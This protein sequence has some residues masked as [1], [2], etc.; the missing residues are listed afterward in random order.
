MRK[1]KTLA[2]FLAIA[3]VFCYMPGMAFADEA[4]ND[5]TFADMPNDW[6]TEALTNAVANGLISGYDEADGAKL[7]K[8]SGDL[9]RAEMA[10]IVNR[11]FG[12]A[13]KAALTGVSD[14][15][16]DAW[17]A[18]EIQKAIK[19]GTF[20]SDNKMRPNDSITR[21]E[22]FT[23][24][25]RAFKVSDSDSNALDSFADKGNVA[26]WAADG[27]SGLVKDGYVAG[28]GGKLNP[29]AS[30]TRAEFAKI[31]DNMVKVY[32]TTAGTVKEVANGNVMINVPG[33][34]LDGVTINGNLIIGDGVGDGDVT[35]NNVKVTGETIVR[36]AG[37]NSFI[38]KG[39][40]DLGNIIVAKV[41]GN[42]RIFVEGGAEVEV[43]YI[44]D[45][46]D[47]VV[48]EG[49]VGSIEVAAAAVP[50]V[51][52]NAT[53]GQINV[54]AE[55]AD[56]TLGNGAT[57]TNVNIGASATGATV[58]AQKGATITNVETNAES[59]TVKGDGTVK[60]VDVKAN[61]T[62]VNTKGTTVKVDK[63]V[64][65]TTAGGKDVSGGT[66]ATLPGGSAAGGGGGGS[67]KEAVSAI[68]VTPTEMELTVGATGT[69]TA[70]VEPDD[71]TNRDVTW[72]S[73]KP[74]VATVD[75]NGLV[76]AIAV[77]E[78]TITATANA[79]TKKT[80]TV[81]VTVKEEVEARTVT[82]VADLDDINVEFGGDYTLPTEVEI[83]LS[84][85]EKVTVPVTWEDTVDVNVA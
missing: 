1:R 54:T 25:A 67:S 70:T 49:K 7:I 41:D 63:G 83:T 62:N 65:G 81:T 30:I 57:V 12:A 31:M 10:T 2:L 53:V 20:K 58:E 44:D 33:V 50:V 74:S 40:S 34:T 36:G 73:D 38:I 26:S 24:L 21:Q 19:M 8:P 4:V 79:D 75:S 55:N 68:S 85:D 6:S 76:T 32:I 78:A 9:T 42:V 16:A 47:D 29:T 72:T 43:I 27:I 37:I 23:V 48:I 66:E 69:I 13:E 52:Q 59:T 60:N 80:A 5:A 82:E 18:G 51:V 35:L 28:S 22:A 61:D 77:G 3:M 84:D 45:G 17:Y 11:A 56:L 39:N 64:E 14:V 71:A 46:K 15:S